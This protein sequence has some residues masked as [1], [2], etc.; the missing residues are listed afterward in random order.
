MAHVPTI[1][2]R[3]SN[4]IV[5]GQTLSAV[6]GPGGLSDAVGIVVIAII[7]LVVSFAVP[8]CDTSVGCRA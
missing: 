2:P 4:C 8:V 6:A 1:S 7:A 3:L 5:G